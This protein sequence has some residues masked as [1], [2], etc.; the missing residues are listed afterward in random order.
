MSD[1][2]RI[3]KMNVNVWNENGTLN[4]A[5]LHELEQYVLSLRNKRYYHLNEDKNERGYIPLCVDKK[6]LS[7]FSTIMLLNLL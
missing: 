1:D 3:Y 7:D 2:R 6:M 5:R 4:H